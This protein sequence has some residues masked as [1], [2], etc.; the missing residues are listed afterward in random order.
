MPKNTFTDVPHNKTN[1]ILKAIPVT[2]T[3][4]CSLK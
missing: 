2:W 3:M 1:A 4:F